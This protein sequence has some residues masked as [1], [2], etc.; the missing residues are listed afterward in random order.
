MYYKWQEANGNW[1]YGAHPPTNVEAFE[2]KTTSSN[3][4]KSEADDT[5]AS[6]STLSEADAKRHALYCETAKANLEALASDAV[7]HRRDETG[8]IVPVGEDEK[9]LERENAE[10]AI[11][12][13]CHPATSL[14]TDG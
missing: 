13:Y 11:E 14:T 12:Q 6:T 8:Q 3:R 2:V 7:I 4:R 5:S 10:Q 1:T 9:E